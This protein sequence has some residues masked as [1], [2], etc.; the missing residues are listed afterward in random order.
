M[1][2]NPFEPVKLSPAMFLTTTFNPA[3]S[4]SFGSFSDAATSP[5]MFISPKLGG[6]VLLQAIPFFFATS[7]AKAKISG[8]FLPSKSF[9]KAVISAMSPSA[10]TPKVLRI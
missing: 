10:S 1:T 2:I 8:V 6:A 7:S 5:K 4:I 3:A 9:P